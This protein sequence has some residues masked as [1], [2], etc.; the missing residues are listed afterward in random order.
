MVH[1]GAVGRQEHCS[2]LASVDLL[3]EI[4]FSRLFLNCSLRCA[5]LHRGARL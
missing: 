1:G 4:Y 2:Q 5:F 3:F